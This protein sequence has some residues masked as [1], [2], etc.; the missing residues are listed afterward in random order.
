MVDVLD[1]GT[2]QENF[3]RIIR[4]KFG[5]EIKIE[6]IEENSVEIPVFDPY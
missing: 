5:P 4:V 2:S 1:E 6:D 3:D